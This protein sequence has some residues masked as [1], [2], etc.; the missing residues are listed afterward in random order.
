MITVPFNML[1]SIGND[2]RNI[3]NIDLEEGVS[4]R[5]L[6]HAAKL[7]RRGIRPKRACSLAIAQAITDEK[8][9]ISAI[10]IIINKIFRS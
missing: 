7:I 3:S 8:D 9:E 4:T 5:S 10:E 2:I 1:E 6:I